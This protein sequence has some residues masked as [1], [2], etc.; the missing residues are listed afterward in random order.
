[1][2]VMPEAKLAREAE[3]AYA[4][5]ALPSDYDCWRPAPADLDKHELLKEIIGNLTAA[6]ANAIALIKAAVDRFGE[7]ADTPSPAHCALELA[8]WTNPAHIPPAV[9]TR[10]APLIGKYV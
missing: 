2:T 8:I 1:M 6:T 4:L 10:L 3:M 7:I 5:V 9:K